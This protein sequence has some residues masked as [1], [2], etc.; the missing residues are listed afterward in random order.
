MT[1]EQALQI[2][3]TGA[4]VFLTG[5]PG[6]GKTHTINEYASYLRCRAIEPAITAST[7]IAATHIGGQTIHSW[8]GIGIRP[9]LSKRDLKNIADNE[10]VRRRVEHAHV[11][12]IDEISMLA[13]ETLSMVDA[14]CKKIKENNKP[15]GGMQ[16]I[17]VGDFFQLPPIVK[18]N[19]NADPSAPRFAYDSPCWTEANFVVAYLTDQFR[20]DD[21]NFLDVLSAIRRNEFGGEHLKYIQRR[22]IQHDK[23][24]DNML[25]LFTHNVDV[26]LINDA[27]LEK[28]PGV[29]QQFEMTGRGPEFMI[30]NL[31]K[32][33]LSPEY[34][35]L[36]AGAAVMFTKNNL[37]KGFVN[38]TLGIVSDFAVE[39]GYPIVK[40]QNGKFIEAEPMEWIIDENGRTVAS[41]TQFPLRLAW[42]ITVHK[43]Q[44]LSLDEAVMDLSDVFEYGQGYVALSRVR[45]LSGL[46]ILG[47]NEQ[48]FKVHP[49]VLKKDK[50]FRAFS[51]VAVNELEKIP[52]AA[53]ENK[54][55][56][57]ISACG[58]REVSG[59]EAPRVIRK[60]K[61][62]KGDS[63]DVT[64]HFF[65]QGKD[66]AQIAKERGLTKGTIVSHL[67]KLRAKNT[68]KSVEMAR[69]LPPKLGKAVKEIVLAFR[70]TEGRALSPVFE[71]LNGRFSYDELRL[72]RLLIDDDK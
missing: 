12:I 32:G 45:R 27:M 9:L 38:G 59:W 37:Q 49:D 19:G 20:Q 64:L 5:E 71:K 43:S 4:N 39:S 29:T 30:K 54:R 47:W 17:L 1:Q 42:A 36:K 70:K 62:K 66:I 51:D 26:D 14:V 67:E 40:T 25:K 44:G 57:F 22:K 61:K 21:Q 8:S 72:V 3:K 69:L 52:A 6:A 16:I 34:L 68:V 11:L 50:K 31:R 46:H 15:F 63:H 33:S 28:L 53:L 48:T 10:Y 13:S 18:N 23:A 35:R 58:G 56:D 7:G 65:N 2:L 60:A 24:K 55:L 41:I